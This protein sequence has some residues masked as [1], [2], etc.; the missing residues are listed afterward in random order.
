MVR[1]GPLGKRGR[2]GQISSLTQQTDHGD[3][4]TEQLEAAV[5][6][7]LRERKSVLNFKQSPPQ[8]NLQPP[9]PNRTSRFQHKCRLVQGNRNA[10]HGKQLACR[11]SGGCRGTARASTSQWPSPTGLGGPLSQFSW[12]WVP[13]P[14]VPLNQREQNIQRGF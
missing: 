2:A 3:T 14:P 7:V 5:A 13:S 1:T 9:S 6:G 12:A 10:P 4:A 8:G 11:V